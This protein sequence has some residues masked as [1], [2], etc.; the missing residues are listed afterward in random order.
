MAQTQNQVFQKPGVFDSVETHTLENGMRF[1]LLPRHDVP[2]ISARILVRAGNVDNNVGQ[3]G[4]AHM[5]EHMAFKGTDRIGTRDHAAELVVQKKVETAG[6]KL[7]AEVA[8][9]YLA[10]AATITRLRTEL[11]ELTEQQIALT[12][13]SEF[14]RLLETYTFDF[15]AST[16]KDFTDYHME[17]PAN[18]IEAWML[19]E[20][21][22]FQHPSFREFYREIEIVKEE[23]RERTEDDPEGL[24]DELLLSLAFTAHPY[25]FPTIGFMS[26]LDALNHEQAETFWKTYYVP[27]NA[28][29]VIVGDFDPSEAKRMLDDYFGDIPA[30]PDPPPIATQEPQQRGIRRGTLRKGTERTLSIAFPGFHPASREASVARLLASVLSK[31]K[32]SRLDKRLDIDEQIVQSIWATANWGFLRYQGLFVIGATPLVSSNNEEV[33]GMIWEELERLQSEPTSDAEL[34]QIREAYR[35]DYYYGLETNSSLA[36]ELVYAQAIH[37]DWRESFKRFDSYSDISANEVTELAADLFQRDRASIVYLEPEAAADEDHSEHGHG[38][39]DD[40]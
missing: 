16:S 23:R 19:L 3:T 25:R 17:L 36:K 22:R 39:Q 12:E 13:A 21:E 4:L 8:K 28:I 6:L 24:A 37:G 27:S 29:G 7:T 14:S 35:K 11:Q 15:N 9:G 26:D 10:D 30:A 18:H 34:D 1:L 31:D 2:S 5:F 38:G 20:S 32:T 40:E 33:E